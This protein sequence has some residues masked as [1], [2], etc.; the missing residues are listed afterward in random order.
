MT[1]LQQDVAK[2]KIAKKKETL[3]AENKDIINDP[4]A[5]EFNIVDHDDFRFS[6]VY[7]GEITKTYAVT[8]SN[9]GGLRVE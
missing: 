5:K 6:C 7:D 2:F 9:L 4:H 8:V 1:Q 3:I